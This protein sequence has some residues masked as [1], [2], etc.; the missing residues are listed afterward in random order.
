MPSRYSIENI[1]QIS[2]LLQRIEDNGPLKKM[3][4]G[5]VEELRR[6]QI[7]ILT[8]RTQKYGAEP[9]VTD[10]HDQELYDKLLL[11]PASTGEFYRPIQRGIP[12]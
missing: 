1:D 8:Q 5:A 10:P 2:D 12:Q 6:L 11:S 7:A 9:V 4:V 3:C